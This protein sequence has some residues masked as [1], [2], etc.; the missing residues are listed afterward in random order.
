MI[1]KTHYIVSLTIGAW[2]FLLMPEA[3]AQDEEVKTTFKN[4]EEALETPDQVQKLVLR[5]KRLKSWPDEVL[6]FPNLKELDLAH[7]K[8]DAFPA[9][10]SALDQLEVLV[11]THNR[12]DSVPDAIGGITALRELY[13]GNNEVYHISEELGRLTRLELL[14]LWSNNIYYLPNSAADLV[15]L[16]EVD[17]RGIQL[18]EGYQDAIK[19]ILPPGV[20]VRMSISCNCD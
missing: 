14:E 10:L 17:L 20:K 15:N 11:L 9:D 16:K 4:L 13:L 7:N 1:S 12:I 18:G 3:M 5:R 6:A 8:I 19:D 2:F